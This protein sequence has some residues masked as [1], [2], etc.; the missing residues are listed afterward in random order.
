MSDLD[1]IE[2]EDCDKLDSDC[3]KI[4]QDE[5]VLQTAMS[6]VPQKRDCNPELSLAGFPT[7]PCNIKGVTALTT[8]FLEPIASSKPPSS[9]IPTGSVSLSHFESSDKPR[10]WSLARTAATG[11]L[12]SSN[13]RTGNPTVDCQLQAARLPGAGGGHCRDLRSLQDSANNLPNTETAYQE[14][15]LTTTAAAPP[16]P[17][18][19]KVYHSGSYNH[20][21]L[22]LHCSSYPALTDTCQYTSIDGRPLSFM[23]QYFP[24]VSLL[25]LKCLFSLI[26]NA[27]HVCWLYLFEKK[28]N[29]CGKYII[30]NKKITWQSNIN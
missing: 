10:I 8:D 12:Q 30:F 19:N 2:D 3:E 11:C 14:G 20:K 9:G 17:S 27:W 24:N 28:K 13:L 23:L 25:L 21:A 26:Q 5:Q 6:T 7:F 4:G 15:P 16:P 29:I 1:D 18:H 22:Q